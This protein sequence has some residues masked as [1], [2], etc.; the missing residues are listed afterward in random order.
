MG[1]SNTNK[2]H[3]GNTCVGMWEQPSVY[4]PSHYIFNT[5]SVFQKQKLLE[6]QEFLC[7][8]G[9]VREKKKSD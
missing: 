6:Q 4:E 7:T 9:K 3:L 2:K 1:A 8:I 5:I